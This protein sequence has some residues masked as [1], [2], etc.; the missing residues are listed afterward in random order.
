MCVHVPSLKAKN[1]ATNPSKT[2]HLPH[3][4]TPTSRYVLH[5][6]N[7]SIICMCIHTYIYIYKY[8]V[9]IHIQSSH[10][11]CPQTSATGAPLLLLASGVTETRLPANGKPIHRQW[12]WSYSS[13]YWL[14]PAS[15]PCFSTLPEPSWFCWGGHADVLV[16]TRRRASASSL[17]NVHWHS[18]LNQRV[19][20]Q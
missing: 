12:C 7:I 20:I 5:V 9:V 2:S 17:L 19:C 6:N 8:C 15:L 14:P 10:V 4:C 11:L 1:W 16:M 3:T 13:M 18:Y